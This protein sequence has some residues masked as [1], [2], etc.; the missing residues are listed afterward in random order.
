MNKPFPRFLGLLPI[1]IVVIAVAFWWRGQQ[2]ETTFA[3]LAFGN[4]RLEATEID[5]ATK[6]HGRVAQIL[7]NE[8]DMVEEGL[9]VAR[10]DTQVLNA[11]LREAEAQKRKAEQEKNVA[12]AVIAQR[13]SEHTFAQQVLKRTQKLADAGVTDQNQLDHDRA[14]ERAAKAVWT[15]AKAQ[16]V[17]AEATIESAKAT[18]ER[19]QADIND[20]ILKSPRYG[21]V[22]YRLA[23]PGEVLAAGGKIL[24][25][26]DITDV[27]MTFYLPTKDAGKLAIGGEARI[28][29]DVIPDRAIPAKISFVS[30]TAQFTPKEVETK[31][32]REKLMFRVKVK[33]DPALLRQNAD[34]VKT[35]LPGVAYVKVDL[36]AEWP[37]SLRSN[38]SVT[39]TNSP[40]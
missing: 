14:S 38:V 5:V 11:Q 20:C 6:L 30:P 2:V 23:E 16:A 21:R 10:M 12:E 3:G 37:A 24:T 7:V 36:A 19:I 32:E 4:G 31:N 9:V 28:V 1:I 27:Y 22:Q 13:E 35:G 29:L 40:P 18:I 33:I 39:S 17:S 8:G 15:A 34:R 26:V 25:L